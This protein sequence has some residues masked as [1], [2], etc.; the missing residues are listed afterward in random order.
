VYATANKDD[1][2]APIGPAGVARLAR[3]SRVPAVGIGGI[4]PETAADVV[5]A[6]AVGVAVIGAILRA[7]DVAEATTRLAAAVQSA[8]APARR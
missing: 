2:Y 1:A 8:Q 6:G 7:P 5:R 3:L 4:T